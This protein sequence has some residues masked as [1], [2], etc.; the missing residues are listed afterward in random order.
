MEEHLKELEIIVR[1]LAEI[2]DKPDEFNTAL[3]KSVTIYPGYD[4]LFFFRVGEILHRFSHFTLALSV[5]NQALNIFKAS[6]DRRNQ[7]ACY[8]NMGS[9]YH[10]IGEIEK[11]IDSHE[12]ALVIAKEMRDKILESKCLGNLGRAYFNSGNLSKALEYHEKALDLAR[13]M[14]DKITECKCYGNIGDTYLESGNYWKAKQY[15]EK[16]IRIAVE[17]RDRRVEKSCYGALGLTY[18]HIGNFGDAIIYNEKALSIAK[19]LEDQSGEL[20][21]YGNLVNVYSSLGE[22]ELAVECHEKSLDIAR[23]IGSRIEE[24]KCYTNGASVYRSLGDLKKAIELH[25]K[26]LEIAE[27]IGARVLESTINGD[28]ANVYA[29]MHDFENAVNFYKEAMATAVEIGDRGGESHCCANIGNVNAELGNHDIAIEYFERALEILKETGEIDLERIV[30]YNMGL[31]QEKLNRNERAYDYFK[32]SIELSEKIGG[33]IVEEVH[34]MGVYAQAE[35]A[36]I[37]VI[38][39]CVGLGKEE[40]AFEYLERS[41]SRTF[42][43]LLTAVDIKPTIELTRKL[44]SLL[45]RE[46]NLLINLREIQTRHLRK[47]ARSIEPGEVDSI[48]KSLELVY[49]EIERLDTEYVFARKGKPCSFEQMRQMVQMDDRQTV[50]LEY[51]TTNNEIF[52][53]VVSSRER[54]IVVRKVTVSSKELSQWVQEYQRD[55]N[56]QFIGV[57]GDYWMQLSRCLIEPISEMLVEGD[58]ICFIPYGLLHYVPLHALEK[59]GKVLIED[60]AV[61]YCPSASLLRLCKNKG[62]RRLASCVSFGVDF[63]KE[64]EDIATLFGTRATIGMSATKEEVVR[65]CR[66]K[67]VIHFSCHGY[68]N[69]RDPLSSGIQ[70]WDGILSAR[71]IFEMRLD[72]GLV[73]LSA[74]ETGLNERRPG[75]ELIG[76]ARA[77][78][79]AGSP[80]LMVSL[81]SVDSDS[82]REL[83][84]K[85]YENIRNGLDKAIALQEAQKSI[86]EKPEYSNPY[87]WAPF[88][89]IG[90]WE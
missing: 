83:M 10:R 72:A 31:L 87:Y 17:I 27:E 1:R 67:D 62:N 64:A 88:I 85:F 18:Y 57:T 58:L 38:K 36:F 39:I 71:E 60:H 48:V 44:E 86:K 55:V 35:N 29:E 84:V 9:V 61:V 59:G 68:F 4:G 25:R 16:A 89:L 66:D 69:E 40:E 49:E 12:R 81:W 14:G 50:L 47:S 15:Y 63:I 53:M 41:K 79:Y 77:F 74:C 76:L 20:V 75:D 19:E 33:T 82:T 28:I 22:L 56:S 65:Y 21:C 34:K 23:K 11:E 54:E 37:H 2:H 51:F 46:E 24:A 78:I 43:E 90:E 45:S 13:E 5:W 73:S 6:G 80:S 42:L 7:A 3:R 30:K 70:L 52:I 32:E 26:A 8:G